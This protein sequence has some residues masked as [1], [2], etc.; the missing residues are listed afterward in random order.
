MQEPAFSP[1]AERNK[2]P[3]L[4][5]LRQ[6]LPARGRALEI[7]S[8]TGQ[9]VAWFAQHLPD[10]TWQPTDNHV[11]ALDN[12]SARMAQTPLP[13][14]RSPLLLDVMKATGAKLHDNSKLVLRAIDGFAALVTVAQARAA[15]SPRI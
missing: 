8:G 13:N 3:I 4:E 1:A 2:Q 9:H 5:V 6:V 15:R 7:A 12:V 11:A 14:L 10:W